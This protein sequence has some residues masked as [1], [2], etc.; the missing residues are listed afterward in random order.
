MYGSP[1]VLL[2]GL[3]LFWRSMDV[4]V[5]WRDCKVRIL[6]GGLGVTDLSERYL[7]L[8][9]ALRVESAS[10]SDW[11]L[12]LQDRCGSCLALEKGCGR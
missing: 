5:D 2:R 10:T 8:D 7:I 4:T 9:S 11:L 3:R 1:G 12:L 6:Q